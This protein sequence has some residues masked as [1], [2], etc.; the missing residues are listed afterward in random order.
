M[1]VYDTVKNDRSW[2]TERTLKSLRWT[3]DWDRHRLVVSD[4]GS[5]L[6]TLDLY[7]ELKRYFPSFRVLHSNRNRGTAV[8]INKGWR[9]REPGEH[10]VKMDNDVVIHGSGW[11]DLMETV[12]EKDPTIG[13]CGLKRKDIEEWPLNEHSFYHSTLV[14]LEHTPGEPWIVVESVEH[15]IGTCQAYSSALLDKM[16]YLYQMQDHGNLYGFDDGLA[17]V[18][19]KVLDFKRVFIPHINIDHIDPGASKYT[20]WKLENAGEFMGLFNKCREQYLSGA[21]DPYYGGP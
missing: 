1:A 21:L 16:G 5:C 14:P 18:R 19:A 4:N 15:V 6:Q 10:C 2:M 9:L 12:F 8:A 20:T 11:A 7:S 13:I 3:V 17:S